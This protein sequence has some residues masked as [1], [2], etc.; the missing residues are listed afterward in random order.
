MRNSQ[1]AVLSALG[2]IVAVM[3]GMAVWF[4]FT[5]EPAPELSG[6]RASRSYDFTNFDRIEIEGQWSVTIERGSAWSIAVETPVEL[7]DNVEVELEGDELSVSYEGGWCSGCSRDG[8]VLEATIT[9]PDIESLDL[10]GSTMLSFSGFDGRSLTVDVSGAVA[11]RGA[12]SRFDMLVLDLSGA[13]S[14]D[15][16]DVPVTDA[17]IDVSGAGNVKLSM[18][19][20]RLTGDMS[21]AGNLEYS[22]TVSEERVEKSGFVNVRRRN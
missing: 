21:G 10:S 13:G 3:L 22:G 18:A 2:L 19:G 6:Q 16:S 20:G 9:M 15:L 17:S 1:F 14:V 7:L 8:N 11:L 4:R 12:S 5:A